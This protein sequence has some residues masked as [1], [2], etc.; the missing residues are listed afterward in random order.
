MPHYFVGISLTTRPITDATA[1]LNIQSTREK[2]K[3]PAKMVRNGGPWASLVALLEPSSSLMIEFPSEEFEAVIERDLCLN[4]NPLLFLYLHKRNH[5]STHLSSN[6]VST[7]I[8]HLN[9]KCNNWI[10][11]S[12]LNVSLISG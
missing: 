3:I 10:R 2:T 5:T 4:S 8:S 9:L 11:I 6:I 12:L 7:N 1:E